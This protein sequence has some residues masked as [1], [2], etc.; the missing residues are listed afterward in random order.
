MKKQLY[1]LAA[2]CT[3][4][5]ILAGG[6]TD[7]LPG[8]EAAAKITLSCK[9]KTLKKGGRFTLKVKNTV[10][11]ATWSVLSGKSKISLKKKGKYAAVIT[12]KKIGTATVQAKAGSKKLTCRITVKDN[13]DTFSPTPA[14]PAQPEPSVSE[15]M[16]SERTNSYY[17][18]TKSYATHAAAAK[19]NSNNN[20]LLTN[21]YACD[22]FAMEYNG[23]VYVYMTNDS[24]QY[25]ATDKNGANG[26]GYIQSVHIISTDDMVNWTDHGIFQIAG[27][28]GV[29]QWANCCWAPSAVHKTVNGQEKFY[30]Y[31]TN[32][33]W[34]VGVVT[35]DTPYGPWKDERGSA[36]ITSGKET[37]SSGLDPAAF[38]DD[39]GTAW[40]TYGSGNQKN[41]TDGTVKD[42]AR[43]RKLNGDMISF[44]EEEIVINAPYMNEDSCLNKIGNTYYYSYCG[45]WSS[46]SDHQMCSILYMTS[47]KVEGPYTYQGDVLPNC[48]SVFKTRTGTEAWGNNHHSILEFKGKYYMFYHTMVLQDQLYC[49]NTSCSKLDAEYLGYRSSAVNE[50]SVNSDGS[51][52]IV[53][54]DL[55][56]VSQI[57]NFDPYR[58][59]SGTVY[60]NCSGMEAIHMDYTKVLKTDTEKRNIYRA[61]DSY[62]ELSYKKN[63]NNMPDTLFES[64][65]NESTGKTTRKELYWGYLRTENGARMEAIANPQH[66]QYSWSTVKGVDFGSTAP[67][68]LTAEF[69]FDA[70]HSSSAGFRVT[71]DS[72]DGTLLAESTVTAGQDGKATV[73]LPVTAITGVHD[74]YFSFNGAVYSFDSWKFEK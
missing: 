19:E 23:R 6:M 50:L 46:S 22:P 16:P 70:T 24:Q 61:L 68:T 54:Q 1:R 27:K 74:I 34:Q 32:G 59:T 20:T 4:S 67:T 26:Y 71:A 39:D 72:T 14:P 55:K 56:G 9:K 33:G 63:D 36:L 66:Y 2:V 69:T 8:A 25:E 64:V 5:A 37:T 38:I 41:N 60:T 47:D 30:M 13:S 58:K 51:L 11:K 45:D 17:D 43:L 29:C 40:L 49:K 48:G 44:A 18:V 12:A 62:T 15:K 21:A 73:S 3:I 57:K 42:G 65:F 52:D 7:L 28:T 10:K 53:R 31:F 35:A